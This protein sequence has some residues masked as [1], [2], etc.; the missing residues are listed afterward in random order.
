MVTQV[1]SVYSTSAKISN[2]FVLSGSAD[3]TIKLWNINS[4]EC[5][6]TFKGHLNVV[7][8][9]EILWNERILS[10]SVDKTIKIWNVWTGNCL[11]TLKGLT[12]YVLFIKA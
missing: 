9:V 6:K 10:G 11:H 12:G 7:S 1:Y 2:E 3:A 8:S 4:V 5:L